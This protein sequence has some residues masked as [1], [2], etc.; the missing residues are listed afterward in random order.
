MK[1]RRKEMNELEDKINDAQKW[2]AVNDRNFDL[3][4]FLQGITPA[5]FH[6]SIYFYQLSDGTF[7]VKFDNEE[8]E[9][10]KAA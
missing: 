6:S 7:I 2:D 4:K 3:E 5:D 10:R 1:S 9:T 8:K